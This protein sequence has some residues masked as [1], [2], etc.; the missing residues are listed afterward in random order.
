MPP[1]SGKARI[2]NGIT[3]IAKGIKPKGGARRA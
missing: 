1:S 2:R 3:K